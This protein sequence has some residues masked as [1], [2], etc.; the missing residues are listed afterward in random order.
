MEVFKDGSHGNYS[1]QHESFSVDP[2][3]VNRG[4]GKLKKP[5]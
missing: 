1:K 5:P 3:N 4:G 2:S